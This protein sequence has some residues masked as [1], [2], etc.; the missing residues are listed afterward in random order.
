MPYFL[1]LSRTADLVR[2]FEEE[3]VWSFNRLGQRVQGFGAL[4]AAREEGGR[5]GPTHWRSG[6]AL[7]TGFAIAWKRLEAFEKR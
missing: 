4:K 7:R 2:G 5:E 1:K 6:V 3:K